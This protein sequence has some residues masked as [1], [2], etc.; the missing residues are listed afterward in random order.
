MRPKLMPFVP[1]P[2]FRFS[3]VPLFPLF[4]AFLVSRFSCPAF[5]AFS[6][7]FSPVP[8]FPIISVLLEPDLR[9]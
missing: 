5:L 2:F 9:Q 8:L 6:V 4:F 1:V 7:R 3:R